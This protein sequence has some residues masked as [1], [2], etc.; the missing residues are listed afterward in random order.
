MLYLN[1][2]IIY[3]W[4]P[5]LRLSFEPH[6]FA[7]TFL[8]VQPLLAEEH[9]T[10]GHAPTC[11]PPLT[12]CLFNAMSANLSV[13]PIHPPKIAAGCWS[14][15]PPDWRRFSLTLFSHLPRF[16]IFH[17]PHPPPPLVFRRWVECVCVCV[18]MMS[19][20]S[21]LCWYILFAAALFSLRVSLF[22]AYAILVYLLAILLAMN[23]FVFIVQPTCRRLRR[24]K[25]WRAN[26][27]RPSCR[28]AFFMPTPHTA[29]HPLAKKKKKKGVYR[30]RLVLPARESD[31]YFQ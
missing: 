19:I 3:I 1:I 23:L 27:K 10:R 11:C 30:P 26:N 4:R 18:L 2:Y 21:T 29:T 28:T 22:C 16:P 25:E 6:T 5:F 15:R 24:P 14:M 7:H 17:L 9:A 13:Q 8:S 31:L 20:F 12:R